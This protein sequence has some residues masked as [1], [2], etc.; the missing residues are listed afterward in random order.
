M[1][2]DAEALS[3]L[4]L[5]YAMSF[6][7]ALLVA[8]VGWWIANTVQR[9]IARA[10]T[11]RRIDSTLASFLSSLARYAVL[12]LMFLVILQ[13]IGIQATSLIA[14]VG[15]ASL[16]IGLALQGT[17]TNV[18]AG[19]MLLLFRPYRLADEIQ[20]GAQRG[21]VKDLNLFMTELENE[22]KDQVLIPNSQIWNAA[23]VNFTAY[24]RAV[25]PPVTMPGTVEPPPAV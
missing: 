18:A 13:L 3:G 19:V 9:M 22:N 21:I 16:A 5:V 14:V 8:I 12:V 6:A 25:P 15:A 10:L 4:V 7:G 17:L 1:V 23:I 20:V 24:K 2:S 11:G